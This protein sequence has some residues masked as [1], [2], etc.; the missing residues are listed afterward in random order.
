MP[1]LAASSR[2]LNPI[3]LRCSTIAFTIADIRFRFPDILC[4]F[5]VSSCHMLLIIVPG[6]HIHS[7]FLASQ[8]HVP[9]LLVQFHAAV[10]LRS[11]PKLVQQHKPITPPTEVEYPVISRTQLPDAIHQ[12]LRHIL[13]K[14]CSVVLQQLDIQH[15][16][17]ILY[18]RILIG[19]AFLSA[20]LP[21]K[22]H[23]SETPLSF[24]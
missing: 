9:L 20:A 23:S 21:K 4:N 19:C 3:A 8:S 7:P 24:S 1:H 11:L 10:F 14:P 12:M 15:D 5:R 2:W 17:F 13:G 16:L 6:P 18:S 22:S